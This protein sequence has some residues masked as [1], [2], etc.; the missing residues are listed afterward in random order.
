MGELFKREGFCEEEF[1]RRRL[2]ERGV[3]ERWRPID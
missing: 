1:P 3:E 2:S